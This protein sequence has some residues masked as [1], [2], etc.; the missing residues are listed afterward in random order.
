[1]FWIA[2]AAHILASV[3]VAVAI[4]RIGRRILPAPL[5]EIG[6]TVPLVVALGLLLILATLPHWHL[7]Q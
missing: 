3:V 2:L 6:V 1:M 5:R 7:M 4:V